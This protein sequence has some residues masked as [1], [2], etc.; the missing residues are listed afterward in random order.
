MLLFFVLGAASAD[1]NT[2][3]QICRSWGVSG[4]PQCAKPL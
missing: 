1:S 4:K 3:G 2:T